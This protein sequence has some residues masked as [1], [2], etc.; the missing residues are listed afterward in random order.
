ME[1]L[2]QLNE[3][4]LDKLFEEIKKMDINEVVDFVEDWH[5]R[6]NGV[7]NTILKINQK[8]EKRDEKE[9]SSS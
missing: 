2:K 7:R 3:E 5:N 6:N 9:K 4:E 1:N 8:I